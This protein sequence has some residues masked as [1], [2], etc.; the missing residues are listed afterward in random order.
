M[1]A[2]RRKRRS[3]VS[4]STLFMCVRLFVFVVTRQKILT[5]RALR[6]APVKFATHDPHA[7]ISNHNQ[8]RRINPRNYHAGAGMGTLLISKT[9]EE[10]PDRMTCMSK[11]SDS[12]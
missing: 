6:L 7:S 3:A 1:T 10:Y 5:S 4:V 9:R 11:V 8:W 12:R 2:R